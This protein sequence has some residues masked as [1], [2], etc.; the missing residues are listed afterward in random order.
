MFKIILSFFIN[1]RIKAFKQLVD[2]KVLLTTEEAVLAFGMHPSHESAVRGF[3]RLKKNP[4]PVIKIGKSMFYKRTD[5]VKFKAS[6]DN[7]NRL[8]KKIEEKCQG[9]KEK[10]L[11]EEQENHQSAVD[12][13]DQNQQGPG[14]EI[15]TS[16]DD[17]GKGT[18]KKDL[19]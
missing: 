19:Y 1:Q 3:T 17:E 2:K 15:E 11:K 4:L 14:D 16:K 5:I 6:S 12:T 10:I 18:S 13:P 8:K 7:F 9:I